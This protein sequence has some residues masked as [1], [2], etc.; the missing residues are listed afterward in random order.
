LTTPIREAALSAANSKGGVPIRKLQANLYDLSQQPGV[1]GVDGL[2]RTLLKTREKIATISNPSL[3]IDANDLYGVRSELRK[4]AQRYYK[5][6][7]TFSYGKVRDSERLIDDAIETVAG[8][9][10]KHYLETFTAQAKRIEQ[11]AERHAKQ[12]KPEQ[13]TTLTA[14]AKSAEL[15]SLPHLLSRPLVIGNYLIGLIKGDIEPAIQKEATRRYLN[16]GAL[17]EALGKKP[18]VLEPEVW[19]ALVRTSAVAGS[20]SSAKQANLSRRAR[21][22]AQAMGVSP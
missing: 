14:P 9:S 21:S 20:V 11:E 22:G 7:D 13:P 3:R 4:V 5:A 19:D 6:G 16:P 2:S 15:D 8:S 18:E 1:Q 17:L 12:Y 10:W